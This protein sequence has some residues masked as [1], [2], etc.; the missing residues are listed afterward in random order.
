MS[1]SC[2]PGATKILSHINT[3]GSKF[4]LTCHNEILPMLCACPVKANDVFMINTPGH[5]YIVLA[6][7][8]IR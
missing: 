8:E 4:C 2:E 6:L 7:S 5:D 3:A 1:N